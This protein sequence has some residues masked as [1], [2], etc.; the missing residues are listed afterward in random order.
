MQDMELLE[1]QLQRTSVQRPT[2]Y[3]FPK[4]NLCMVDKDGFFSSILTSLTPSR[5]QQSS[6]SESDLTILCFTSDEPVPV[7]V[8]PAVLAS[9]SPLL[10]DLL[11]S[12]SAP[13]LV[14]PEVKV[15]IVRNMLDLLC[16]GRWSTCFCDMN[17]KTFFRC[18]LKKDDVI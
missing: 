17:S 4:T 9:Q 11:L 3:S 16:T 12:V 5:F 8:H 18:N 2:T 7:S 14:L 1:D 13:V 6:S 10:Q 15:E